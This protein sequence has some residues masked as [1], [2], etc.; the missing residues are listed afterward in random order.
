MYRIYII[1]ALFI[2]LLIIGYLIYLYE[3]NSIGNVGAACTTNADCKTNLVCS[4]KICVNPSNNNSGLLN[5][6]VPVGQNCQIQNCVANGQCGNITTAYCRSGSI[7]ACGIGAG[8]GQSCTTQEACLVG[9]YCAGNNTCQTATAS[10]PV[11]TGETCATTQDCLVNNTCGPT[12]Q[13]IVGNFTLVSINNPFYLIPSQLSNQFMGSLSTFN[14]SLVNCQGILC[15]TPNLEY[16]LTSKNF[17]VFDVA[18][19]SWRQIF[20]TSS[21]FLNVSG[22]LSPVMNQFFLYT[23]GTNIF[24]TDIYNNSL[25]Y[26]ADDNEFLFYDEVHYSSPTEYG[27]LPVAT[28]FLTFIVSSH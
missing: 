27:S 3:R 13:C 10:L 24:I 23:N 16:N 14:I 20:V 12:G 15:G 28:F 22:N 11:A 9:L 26:K 25:R 8:V 2:L 21:G 17:S 6:G 18:S 5:I 7:C 1:I 4:S 19:N